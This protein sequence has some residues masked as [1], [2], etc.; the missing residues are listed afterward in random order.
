M[1][2]DPIPPG[3][4]PGPA[5]E[6]A[7]RSLADLSDAVPDA[8][9]RRHVRERFL[10]GDPAARE[11]WGADAPSEDAWDDDLP[12]PPG[13]ADHA[14]STDPYRDELPPPPM[15]VEPADSAEPELGPRRIARR[16]WPWAAILIAG[17][18]LLWVGSPT[19]P[20]WRLVTV[21]GTG[22]IQIGRASFTTANRD[23]IQRRLVAGAKVQ[24]PPTAMLELVSSGNVLMQIAPG[25][26]VILPEPRRMTLH[27]IW[28]GEVRR[29]VLRL[30]TGPDFQGSRLVLATPGGDV[31]VTGTT[32]A[33][34][35]GEADTCVCVL[36]G[37]VRIGAEG[38]GPPVEPG[39][40]RTRFFPTGATL[41]QPLEPAESDLLEE[42]RVRAA[43]MIDDESD[44]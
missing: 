14:I 26:E 25:S 13:V 19:D 31:H 7:R 20:G 39:S 21:E 3:A 15:H 8:S 27:P 22:T 29:G 37:L 2:H 42:L 6:R 33:V 38:S 32:L 41:D 24:L 5:E 16:R 9:F 4:E 30:S 17:F 10:A 18:T 23:E 11:S 43:R 36:E 34:V 12:P 40:R 35:C 1:S 28:D 44:Y